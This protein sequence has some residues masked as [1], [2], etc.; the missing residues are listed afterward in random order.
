M[1]G[2]HCPGFQH[3]SLALSVFEHSIAGIVEC[4]CPSSWLLPPNITLVDSRVLG[5]T[6]RCRC[7]VSIYPCCPI[8]GHLP[9]LPFGTTT[10]SSA[11]EGWAATHPH[12][13]YMT[14]QPRTCWVQGAP[15]VSSCGYPQQVPRVVASWFY[16]VILMTSNLNKTTTQEGKH[17]TTKHLMYPGMRHGSHQRTALSKGKESS[18]A[19]TG[20]LEFPLGSHLG[21]RG[22]WGD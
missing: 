10:N 19:V 15:V 20:A 7:V 18:H 11:L 14:V 17:T 2:S 21:G 8:G 6:H 16:L 5:L 1:Q 13:C 4:E 22:E 3:H 12:A 9:S